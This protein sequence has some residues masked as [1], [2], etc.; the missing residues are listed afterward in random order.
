[1]KKIIA[2]LFSSMMFAALSACSAGEDSSVTS[3]RSGSFIESYC[4]IYTTEK[5]TMYGI[6]Y[7]C[8]DNGKLYI[9]SATEYELYTD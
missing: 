4:S 2:I 8:K 3:P 7:S 1:M 5:N 6:V 9:C